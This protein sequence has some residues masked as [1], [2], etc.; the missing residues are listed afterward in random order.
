MTAVHHACEGAHQWLEHLY[1]GCE[2]WVTLFTLDRTDGTRHTDWAPIDQLGQLADRAAR[3]AERGCVWFGV[4]TRK[5]QLG[6]GKRGGA[7]DCH[8]IPALWADIDVAGPNHKGAHQLPPTI[9]AALELIKDFPLVPSAVVKTGGGLQAWWF[10]TEPLAVDAAA[11]ELLGAWGATWA[12]LG[13]RRSWHVDN[14]FD[15]AR[16]MRLPGTTNRKTVPTPVTAKVSWDTRYN[17]TDF[18]PHLLDVP[19]A[20]EPGVVRYIGPDRPGDAFNAVRRGGDVLSAVGFTLCRRDRNGE[21]HWVRPGKDPKDGTSATV[22]PDGHTTLW[23][24]T[25]AAQWSAVELRRPYDPFGLYV[26]LFHRGDFRA[27]T[28]ELAAEGYGAVAK[29]R[30][31]LSWVPQDVRDAFLAPDIAEEA[32]EPLPWPEMAPE[33]YRGIV[34][35]IVDLIAPH[36]EADPVGILACLLTYFAAAVGAGPHFRLSGGK[37]S[38]RLNTIIVGDSARARKGS[39]EAMTRWIMRNADPDIATARRMNGLNSGEGLIEAVRDAKWGRDKNGNDILVDDGVADK[40]LLLFESEFAGR[41]MPA[42]RR[43]GS[44]VSGLLRMAWD[45]GDL[46][47][48]NAKNPLRATGAHVCVLGNTTIDELL[49]QMTDA[50]I[51]G[52]LL[53]RFLFVAVRSTHLLPFGGTLDDREVEQAAQPLRA[54]LD[55]ARKRTRVEFGESC[56]ESW[57]IAYKALM[58]DTPAGPLGHLTARGPTQVQRLALVYALLDGADAIEDEHLLAGVAFWQYCRDSAELVLSSDG[59]ITGDRDSDRMLRELIDS[60]RAWRTD[61]LRKQL[62]DGKWSG[63][64]IATVRARLEKA[65]LVKVWQVDRSS[66]GRPVTWVEAR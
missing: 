20:P 8:H 12:E 34:G 50:D 37:Q 35:D 66:G 57:P 51:Q 23:S 58:D 56:R 14:V 61:E 7:D 46:Q 65:G 63:A 49:G 3:R 60:G 24:D 55:A 19:A 4:A 15:A 53:N 11:H 42:I 31:D 5:E 32:P 22:Y 17:V 21:E 48:M 10:L 64:K 29:A 52:G 40:R 59:I 36:T 28:E 6:D 62:G 38:A 18:E 25:I 30:D 44:T 39:A 33:A 45:E 41:L 27:A 16:I 43:Q 47:T 9:E 1:D 26:V 54:A 13:R 2:G